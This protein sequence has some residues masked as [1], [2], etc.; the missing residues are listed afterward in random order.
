M[1]FD[2]RAKDGPE[3]APALYAATLEMSAW[4]E[5][6]GCGSVQVS[7]H[8]GSPDGYL[9]APIPL[10]SA[11]AA[12]TSTLPIQVAALIVPLH[13]PIVLAQD[14]AVADLISGG[15]I[16]YVCAVG[17]REEEYAMYGRSM[18][19]RGR[20]MEESLEVLR[21]AWSGE[22]F[23]Y[24]G[25]PVRVTPV[26]QTPGGPLL[27]MGGNAPV[28]ARR[29][30]R[31]GLG[32]IAQGGEPELERVYREACEE[33]GHHGPGR[34][35]GPDDALEVLDEERDRTREFAAATFPQ[36]AGARVLATR[37]CLYCDSWDGDFLIDHDP[38]H[39]GLVVAAGGSGHGFKF[40]PVLGEIVADVVEGKPGP[41]AERFAWRTPGGRRAEA[42]RFLQ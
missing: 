7:E 29:A 30:A 8:H 14:M 39:P 33:F 4:A 34:R 2:L 17:Y 27:M 9:P 15:R 3:S 13:D 36:L 19:E 28:V 16:S 22:P 41:H 6:R 23:E 38:Q 18:R 10:A 35:I 32:M 1:R 12:R 5:S 21:R 20:R 26:P 37:L 42:A 11:I 31:F 24:E 40:A 25:R